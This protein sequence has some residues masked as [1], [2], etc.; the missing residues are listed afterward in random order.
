MKYR[1]ILRG[2]P[3]LPKGKQ[4]FAESL[5]SIEA[6]ANATLASYPASSHPNALV[7]IQEMKYVHVKEIKAQ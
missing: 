3:D 6:W 4:D 2:V 7:E 5:A 1:A